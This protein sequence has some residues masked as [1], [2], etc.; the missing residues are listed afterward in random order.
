M[1]L[2]EG[3]TLFGAYSAALLSAWA[4]IWGGIRV[5]RAA[6]HVAEEVTK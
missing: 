6:R 5:F 1:T 2:S 4:S 3:F